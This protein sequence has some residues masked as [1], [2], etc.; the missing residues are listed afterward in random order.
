MKLKYIGIRVLLLLG[1]FSVFQISRSQVF[2]ENTYKF[3]KV[4][5]WLDSYYVDSVNQDELVEDA[6]VTLLHELD[7]H[8]AYISKEEVQRMNEPLEGNFE[9]IGVSFN[10]LKD[11][12][13]VVSPIAGG[14]SEKVGIQAGDRIVKIENKNVAGTGITNSD[15]FDKLRG[16]KGTKVDVSI[17][18][19][20]V[21]QLLEFT[22]TRDKIPIYSIDASYKVNDNTGYIKLNRFASTTLDEFEEAANKLKKQNVHNLILDLSGNGGGYLDVAVKLADQFLSDDK[23]IVYTEGL[24][25]PR[26]EYNAT[27]KGDFEKGNV[28]IIIDEG[29]ASASE[30]VAGAIQDWDR[31]V[32]VGRRSFGKG[33]VQRPL[34]LPDG[35]VIRLTVARYYT[36]TGRLIQKPYNEGYDAYAKDIVD[37]YKKGEFI[38][39]DSINF[40]DS[41]K[42]FTLRKKRT[43]YGGGGIM[44]HIFVPLDTAGYSDYYRDLIRKGVLYQFVLNFVDNNR[45]SILSDYKSFKNYKNNFEIGDE[46]FDQLGKFAEKEGVKSMDKGLEKSKEQISLLL[47]AYMARDLWETTNFYQ[48]INEE[49]PS[50][51]TA[52]KVLSNWDKYL[53]ELDSQH[54]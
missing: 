1:L 20:G 11:T 9:G 41:L 36:P 8:S 45:K 52:L 48:V 44:P 32:I 49:D 28:V 13:Y 25:S 47:K 17:K 38:H 37:R 14:P 40:P 16:K 33:L 34:M 43:V 50:V 15:V 30:I 10:I 24:H 3:S 53:A 5:D 26:R 7:P 12:I 35:S 4:I 19:K 23:L 2:N 21:D 27:S 42:Y 51:Q 29:S 54:K 18:R 6:I 46:I 31:G 22:I 39:S